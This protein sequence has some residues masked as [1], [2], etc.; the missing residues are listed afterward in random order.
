MID[1]DGFAVDGW[2]QCFN[3]EFCPDRRR[4]KRSLH[5][6]ISEAYSELYPN[7]LIE[8]AAMENFFSFDRNQDG[9]ISLEDPRRRYWQTTTQAIR[10]LKKDSSK[11]IWTM[12]DL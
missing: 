2:C 1:E 8:Q 6:A 12:M 3:D 10:A 11:L 5:E 9:L 7:Y 4:R